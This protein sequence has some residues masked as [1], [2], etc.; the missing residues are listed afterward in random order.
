[1]AVHVESCPSCR[2]ERVSSEHVE[3]VRRLLS[4]NMPSARAAAS[5]AH[6]TSCEACA[7]RA[8]FSLADA[9][10]RERVQRCIAEMPTRCVARAIDS[11]RQPM[12]LEEALD[13]LI[14]EEGHGDEVVAHLH[15]D[16]LSRL[17][18]YSRQ[19]HDRTRAK[20]VRH[21]LSQE[22]I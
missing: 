18:T 3:A 4:G 15:R 22:L 14:S 2:S 19:N 16:T 9:P 6:G 13:Y 21:R 11:L 10:L 1:M 8:L 12:Q 7:A 17:H 20:R 5:Q